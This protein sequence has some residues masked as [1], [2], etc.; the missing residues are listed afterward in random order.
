VSLND[1]S[2]AFDGWETTITITRTSGSYVSGRWVEDTP[3]EIAIQG[4]VQNATPE[5]L[6]ALPEGQR[7]TEAIKIHTTYKLIAQIGNT[8]K[9]D[10]VSHDNFNWIVNNVAHRGIGNYHK[11]IATRQQC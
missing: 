10:V 4:V 6:K 7:T 9:G 1:V 11:A 3:K 2:D 5:D 8:T